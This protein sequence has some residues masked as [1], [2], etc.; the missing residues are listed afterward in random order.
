MVDIRGEWDNS[1]Q[2]FYL[3]DDIVTSLVSVVEKVPSDFFHLT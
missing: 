3:T 1:I 2:K